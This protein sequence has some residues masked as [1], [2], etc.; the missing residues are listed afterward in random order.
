MDEVFNGT[1]PAEGQA[2]A[3]SIAHH[4]S[5]FPNSICMIATHF[6]RLTEL[7]LATDSFTNYKVSVTCEEDG[8]L[9][10]PF[11]LEKGNSHQ[12]VA[13]D[14]L[15]LEGVDNSIVTRAQDFLDA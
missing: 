6:A 5:Q 3:Y 10:Y 14:M 12:H 7:E 4:A 13:F 9:S 8:T 11:K 15:R 2:A 1:T